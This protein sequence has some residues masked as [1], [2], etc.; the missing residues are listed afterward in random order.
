M[1]GYSR[2]FFFENFNYKLRI[3]LRTDFS[4]EITLNISDERR[5][6]LLLINRKEKKV[7]SIYHVHGT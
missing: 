4:F 5:R 1:D 3:S 6:V 7:G 2:D